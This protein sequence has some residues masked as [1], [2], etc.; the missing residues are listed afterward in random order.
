MKRITSFRIDNELH[1]KIKSF[2][3]YQGITT[4]QLIELAC[5]HFMEEQP[6]PVRQSV[7]A[8][9]KKTEK[10]L[11]DF[12]VDQPTYK[13]LAEIARTKNS[14]LSQ[15]VY[16][17]VSASLT[18]PIFDRIEFAKLEELHFDLN[19]LGNLLKLAI[20]NKTPIDLNLLNSIQQ[21]ISS[22]S[23]EIDNA[24]THSHKRTL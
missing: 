14:T 8:K 11:L 21:D 23:N 2:A 1:G 24:I 20:N 17:R 16:Y 3:E 10:I 19:R 12:Q 6:K 5:Y 15:E 13:K 22:I 4:S 18:A 9:D 7:K